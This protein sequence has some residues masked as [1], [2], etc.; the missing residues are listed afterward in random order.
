MRVKQAAL[1]HYSKR[2]VNTAPVLPQYSVCQLAQS[3]T[4]ALA[5]LDLKVTAWTKDLELQKQHW[6][7]HDKLLQ[8][9]CPSAGNLQT[10]CY[11]LRP[12]RRAVCLKAC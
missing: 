8:W 6:Q 2:L 11:T 7:C 9:M 3:H 10:W 4:L 1:Q 5:G 12:V